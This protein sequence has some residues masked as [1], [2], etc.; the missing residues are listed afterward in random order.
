MFEKQT[1][2]FSLFLR[3]KITHHKLTQTPDGQDE[4]RNAY[5]F[6]LHTLDC[7]RWRVG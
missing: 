4:K 1:Q 6:S 5:H 7:I 2:R 3:A